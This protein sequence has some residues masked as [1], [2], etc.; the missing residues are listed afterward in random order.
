M[1]SEPALLSPDEV[2]RAR[3]QAQRILDGLDRTLYDQKALTRLVVIGCL[4][5]GHVLLEVLPGLA[6]PSWSRRSRR[7]SASPSSACSSRP[8]SCPAT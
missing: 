5:R 7:C 4:A 3:A 1:R 2:A 8:T 6:R